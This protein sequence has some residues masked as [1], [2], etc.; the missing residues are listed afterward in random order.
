M[1]FIL[2]IGLIV[3][4]LVS[5][6]DAQESKTIKL[7]RRTNPKYQKSGYSFRY[8]AQDEQRHKN[9]VDIV[10]EGGIMRINN[11]GGQKNQIVDL[12]ATDGLSKT[13]KVDKNELEWTTDLMS[14]T[15][16][17]TYALDVNASNK[18]MLVVFHV[19]KVT[20]DMMEFKW[21]QI[22]GPKTWPISLQR[23]GAAGTS[24]MMG[25]AAQQ[26]LKLRSRSK[27]D[28]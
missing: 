24:G 26:K 6:T 5:T 17:H 13:M 25:G 3:A 18:N 23:R 20:E 15:E 14:P 11:H 10:Y 16:G 28:R 9:Y 1:R 21:R 27:A 19:S 7:E 8:R 12:G 4:A 22:N 2:V